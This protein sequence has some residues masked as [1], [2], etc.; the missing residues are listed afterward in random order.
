MGRHEKHSGNGCLLIPDREHSEFGWLRRLFGPC[1][2]CEI[3]VQMTQ[4]RLS[5]KIESASCDSAIAKSRPPCVPPMPNHVTLTS[6]PRPICHTH[7]TYSSSPGRP[8]HP[9]LGSRAYP[10][11]PMLPPEHQSNKGYT[12]DRPHPVRVQSVTS[13]PRARRR[14]LVPHI[15]VVVHVRHPCLH[16][17]IHSY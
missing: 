1:R 8:P 9:C 12:L 3:I 6:R 17:N 14:P 7:E 5:P 13:T 11:P 2:G 16:N 10:P 4:R 15:R